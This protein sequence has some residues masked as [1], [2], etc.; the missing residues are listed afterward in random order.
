MKNQIVIKT[1]AAQKKQAARRAIMER[2]LS[3]G[4]VCEDCTR[5]YPV[6]AVGTPQQVAELRRKWGV[7]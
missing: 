5:P 4:I 7:V 2:R 3:L 1:D 6:D